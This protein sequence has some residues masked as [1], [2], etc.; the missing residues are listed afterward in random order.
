[1]KNIL[2]AALL[3]CAAG[4]AIADNS[5]VVLYGLIDM[6]YSWRGDNRNA[7]VSSRQGI[8]GGQANGSRIGFKGE[9]GLG[10]GLKALFTLEAGILADTGGAAQGGL[11]W[12]RQSF[13]G[14]DKEG[15]GAI[16]LGRQYTP[17][18]TLWG[19]IDPFSTGSVGRAD[20]IITP[21]IAYGRADN[22]VL[23]STPFFGKL[24][25]MK[26]M[27]STNLVGA[28]TAG[29][30]GNTRYA[31]VV[32]RVKLLDDRLE[33]G[34][35]WSQWKRQQSPSKNEMWDLSAIAR[36]P[37]ATLSTA[38]S[39]FDN[40]ALPDGSARLVNGESLKLDRYFAGA[41]IP[42]DR[43]TIMTSYAYSKD[44][45]GAD[46]KAQ[47]LA[48]GGRYAFSTRT[49]VYT[50]FSRILADDRTSATCGYDV[51]DATTLGMGYR[52]GLNIG[53]TH[54]F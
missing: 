20:N 54:V 23:L 30:T 49:S 3:S 10:N 6:G 7:N 22:A 36:L 29:D 50:M 47:Q 2:C 41:K 12:G 51:T 33:L 17:V 52:T 9:E 46:L 18:D 32:P 4:T 1:M 43:L 38:Y 13:V 19:D 40:G 26:A 15:I 27:Y 11:A 21:L 44:R 37:F 39:R 24:F 8:D 16:T 53:V 35:S 14:L 31:N 5:N 34:L 45:N 28:E 48:L 42:V 25:A